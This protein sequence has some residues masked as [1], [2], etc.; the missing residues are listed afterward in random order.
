MASVGTESGEIP[1][2]AFMALSDY[3][4]KN[5]ETVKKFL[6]AML[7]AIRYMNETDEK[8]VAQTL[9]KQ[10]PGTS[11]ES[12][13]TALASYRKIDAWSEDMIMKETAFDNLQT[14]M[15]NAGELR[16]KVKFTDIVDNSYAFSVNRDNE[17]TSES[18]P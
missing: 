9:A 15:E 14:V 18:Q 3:V 17:K 12:V 7:A 2:T 6:S 13:A 5:E 4:K 1:Y 16:K 10:F 8:T 11:V